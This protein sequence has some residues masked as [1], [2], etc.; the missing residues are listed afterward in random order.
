M[1]PRKA[2]G[3]T[4]LQ[5]VV[6]MTILAILAAILYPVVLRS[7]KRAKQTSC[8]EKLRQISLAIEMYRSD[9]GGAGKLG[10]ISFMGLPPHLV[11]LG[12]PRESYKC[13]G[14][15][16]R[17][18]GAAFTY[19]ADDTRQWIAFVEKM[20]TG[21]ILVLDDNHQENTE[22]DQSPPITHFVFGYTIGGE[23]IKRRH[24]GLPSTY[25]FWT[26]NEN[27]GGNK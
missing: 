25:D 14:D 13:L 19:M 20:G 22:T 2:I 6:A 7:V 16:T 23:F 1:T 15:T 11:N 10:S 12:L 5:L 8:E 9:N 26:D 4:I 3:F 21:G 27:N 18:A 17:A 24:L